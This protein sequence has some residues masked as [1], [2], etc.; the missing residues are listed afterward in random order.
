MQTVAAAAACSVAAAAAAAVATPVRL[1]A[2]FYLPLPLPLPLATVQ[3][4]CPADFRHT[5]SIA[6]PAVC[7]GHLTRH[8]KYAY[9]FMQLCEWQR[10]KRINR[11]LRQTG[12]HL[13]LL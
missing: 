3:C 7:F 11:R 13:A 6:R 5:L 1:F 8:N 9:K 2:H 10:K 12:P 4:V